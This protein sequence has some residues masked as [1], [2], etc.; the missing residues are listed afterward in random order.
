[1]RENLN[2]Q[3]K[4]IVAKTKEKWVAGISKDKAYRAKMYANTL[5]EG[6]VGEQHNMLNLY[7]A[8]ILRSNQ[9]SSVFMKFTWPPEFFNESPTPSR[10]INCLASKDCTS[11]SQVI[12][13][14]LKYVGSLLD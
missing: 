10:A 2:I 13:N 12:V 7:C 8:E 9:D 3:L 14:H 1:M 6:S 5:L 11:A 4:Q